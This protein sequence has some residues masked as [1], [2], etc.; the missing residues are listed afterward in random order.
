MKPAVKS[1]QRTFAL[2]AVAALLLASQPAGSRARAAVRQHMPFTISSLGTPFAVQ[3]KLEG[4]Y[5]VNETYVEVDVERA[6]IYVSEHCPYKGRR[7]VNTLAI[8]LATKTPS[9][10]WEIEN[11]SLPSYVERVMVPR[12]E[13]SLAGLHFQIPRSAGADLSARWLV[14]ETEELALDVPDN[15]RDEKGYAFAHSRRDIFA[16]PDAGPAQP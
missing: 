8:G 5:T 14:V 16:V 13:Y 7:V 12:E 11:R 4:T 15:E 1:F 10:R 2:A 9:G 3:V 6:F